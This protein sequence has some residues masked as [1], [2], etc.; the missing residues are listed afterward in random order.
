[1]SEEPENLVPVGDRYAQKEACEDCQGS[2][3]NISYKS[4][5]CPGCNGVGWTA[6]SNGDPVICPICR[7][8]RLVQTEVR[9]TC[10]KCDGRGYLVFIM[11]DY[12]GE[13]PC[14]TCEGSGKMDCY[15]VEENP[16]KEDCDQCSGSGE[17]RRHDRD[18]VP[19]QNC[20]CTGYIPGSDFLKY[21]LKQWM[22]DPFSKEVFNCF[23]SNCLD[24]M[25]TDD[26]L[27]LE[28][29]RI[30][31]I[32][33]CPKCSYLP[34]DAHCSICNGKRIIWVM[35]S[36]K[37]KCP[38]CMGLGFIAYDKCD[39]CGGDGYFECSNCNG[40][41]EDFCCD[42]GGSG[43]QEGIISRKI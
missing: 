33:R 20:N 37:V 39:Q 5:P 13:V 24:E 19:C 9:N 8:L 23:G 31:K 21:G 16:G 25:K 1:M 34:K 10:E 35:V 29:G 14:E 30:L 32:S 2:G 15:C 36:E 41:L 26:Q 11:Q 27:I 3:C 42:C 7:G 22:Q 17:I 18:W 43:V 40:T 4:D 6:N 12:E 28:D 38:T